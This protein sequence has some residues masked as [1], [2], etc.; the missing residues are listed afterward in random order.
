M[1]LKILGLT[2]SGIHYE[3]MVGGG[4]PIKPWL[5]KTGRRLNEAWRAAGRASLGETSEGLTCSGGAWGF[6]HGS[7]NLLTSLAAVYLR[8]RHKR[9]DSDR[10]TLVDTQ[11]CFRFIL[12]VAEVFFL[13]AA[14]RDKCANRWFYLHC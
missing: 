12:S 9:L 3:K 14:Q 6:A 11:R 4:L 5:N 10:T 2:A 8:Y 13:T 1:N 7:K